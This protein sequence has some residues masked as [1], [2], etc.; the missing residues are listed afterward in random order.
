MP[1]SEPPTTRAT[2]SMPSAS[3]SAHWAAAWS[4]VE[5]DGKRAPYGRPVR[6]STDVGPVVP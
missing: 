3:S 2:R 6:G 5:I 4:R 1:P